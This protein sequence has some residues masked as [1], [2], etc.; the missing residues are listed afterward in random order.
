MAVTALLPRP[1]KG[2][3]SLM[4]DVATHD[5]STHGAVNFRGLLMSR[6]LG[7]S[8][9]H[10]SLLSLAV[11]NQMQHV[12]LGFKKKWMSQLLTGS[13]DYGGLYSLERTT[14]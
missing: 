10:F 14:C 4:S 6:G 11:S 7:R 1:D 9:Q 2:P 5:V 12:F 3:S 8:V 13:S